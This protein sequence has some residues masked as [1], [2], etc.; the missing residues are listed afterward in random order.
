MKSSDSIFK[1]KNVARHHDK[2][3][4]KS[5]IVLQN[6]SFIQPVKFFLF[7]QIKWILFK[8]VSSLHIKIIIQRRVCATFFIWR[9][10]T[11]YKG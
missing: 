2:N 1:L 9:P 10:T 11:K 3:A 8:F 7:L 4:E 6:I 5:V